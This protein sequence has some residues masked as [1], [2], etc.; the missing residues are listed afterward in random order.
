MP[1]RVDWQTGTLIDVL[2]HRATVAPDGLVYTF[3]VDGERQAARLTHGQ[4]DRR[5]R[6]LAGLLQRITR[7]G[8]RA[9]LLYPDGLEY[10]VGLFGCLYAGVV[11]VS[12]VPPLVPRSV[13]RFVNVIRDCAPAVV[14]GTS[15]VLGDVQAMAR[16]ELDLLALRWIPTERLDE[17]NADRWQPPQVSNAS[18]ALLQYTS[19]STGSPRG[20]LLTHRNLLHNL[21][22]QM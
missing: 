16:D 3:L 20:V 11:P 22:S 10:I 6:T 1:D 2:T 12:G 7:P 13:D 14:I 19:G 17:R 9:L 8:D 15:A 21:E 4:L 18:I 5:A